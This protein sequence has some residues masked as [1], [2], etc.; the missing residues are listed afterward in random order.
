MNERDFKIKNWYGN[1][2]NFVNDLKNVSILD[3][4]CGLG[5][6]LSA[7]ND[8]VKKFGLEE[9]RFACDYISK[10]FKDIE[11]KNGDYKE[12]KNYKQKFDVIMFYHVIEHLE[13]PAE[14]IELIKK[15]ERKWN[16]NNWNSKCK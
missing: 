10:N 2:I 12:I 8:N 15:F 16:F 11:I 7:L 1:A 4:G 14:A 13:K 6:F 5:Y 9:S 3:I